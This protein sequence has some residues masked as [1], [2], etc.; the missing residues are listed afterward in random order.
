LGARGVGN[1]ARGLWVAQ[2]FNPAIPARELKPAFAAEV[3][4]KFKVVFV[5]LI[6]YAFLILPLLLFLVAAIAEIRSYKAEPAFVLRMLEIAAGITSLWVMTQVGQ[7]Q[8]GSWAMVLA[9]L[10]LGGV[11]LVSKYA[12][13]LA[14][15]CVLTGSAIVAFLWYFKGAYHH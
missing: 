6:E 5:I 4:R 3:R 9:S 8:A 10:L 11:S 7:S 1:S 12:S 15:R 2:R 14:L 13:R